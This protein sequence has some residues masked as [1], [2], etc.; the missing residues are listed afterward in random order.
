[1]AKHGAYAAGEASSFE[2]VLELLLAQVQCRRLAYAAKPVVSM[3]AVL[4]GV[5]G[6]QASK[7]APS[8]ATRIKLEASYLDLC[9]LHPYCPYIQYGRKMQKLALAL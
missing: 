7:I 8:S 4:A 6:S 5:C 2:Q 3:S 1:M 9:T